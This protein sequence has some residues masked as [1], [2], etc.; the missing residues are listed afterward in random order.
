M[1]VL[2]IGDSDSFSFLFGLLYTSSGFVILDTSNSFWFSIDDTVGRT[3]VSSF[4]SGLVV[5]ETDEEADDAK[6]S[7]SALLADIS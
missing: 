6:W 7:A 3:G 4:E 1:Y 2:S 5:I